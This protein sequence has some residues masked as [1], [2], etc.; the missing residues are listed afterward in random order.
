VNQDSRYCQAEEGGGRNKPA[1]LKKGQERK[2]ERGGKTLGEE[3]MG[4]ATHLI[5]IAIVG[6]GKVVKRR[7]YKVLSYQETGKTEEGRSG[8]GKGKKL[9]PRKLSKKGGSMANKENR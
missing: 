2:G 7:K 4:T 6:G 5:T 3:V 8:E 1:L 9:R